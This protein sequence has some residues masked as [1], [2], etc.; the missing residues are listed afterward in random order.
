[1]TSTVTVEEVTSCL[2]TF[3]TERAVGEPTQE[4]SAPSTEGFKCKHERGGEFKRRPESSV[5]SIK[6]FERKH[7]SGEECKQ[8][9][10]KP[11][12]RS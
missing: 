12:R 3:S 2:S 5:P 8:T 11:I 10:D 4:S 1:M 6:G 9:Q 7:G